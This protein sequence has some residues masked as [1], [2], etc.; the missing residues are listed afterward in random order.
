MIDTGG[1]ETL[2]GRSTKHFTWEISVEPA[3]GQKQRI[4]DEV[5]V[6]PVAKRAYRLQQCTHQEGTGSSPTSDGCWSVTIS[7]V[8]EPVPSLP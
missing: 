2:D 1:E 4:A 7:K 8:N 6:D 5:W 3:Q